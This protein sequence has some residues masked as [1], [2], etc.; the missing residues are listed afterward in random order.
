MAS[1]AM[2]ALRKAVEAAT[3]DCKGYVTAP[4]L[5]NML[6][7]SG[8]SQMQL[9]RRRLLEMTR[10]GELEK[11]G[12]GKWKR[13]GKEL[14]QRGE[15]YQ[16]MWRAI[17]TAKGAFTALE[18][19]ELTSV[20]GTSVY[21]FLRHLEDSGLVRRVGREGNTV[22]FMLTNAGREQR[23]T[24]FPSKD[25][26]NPY[27]AESAATAALCRIFLLKDA[28]KPSVRRKIREHLE[29]LNRRFMEAEQGAN[30]AEQEN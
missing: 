27:H 11:F 2:D 3:P 28:N 17:R 9:I 8:E 30:Y 4:Q 22:I 12:Q 29:I 5:A 10:R 26:I 23:K 24:P 25:I 15:G 16:K 1:E 14:L 6:G 19:I 18:I 13:T 21:K 20:D 7:V